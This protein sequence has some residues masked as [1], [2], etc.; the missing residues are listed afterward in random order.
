M[1]HVLVDLCRQG[2]RR[3]VGRTL[4]LERPFRRLDFSQRSND[5]GSIGQCI[6]DRCRKILRRLGGQGFRRAV[7]DIDLRVGWQS[8]GGNE[9]GVSS[10][11]VAARLGQVQTGLRGLPPRLGDH[12]H[13]RQAAFQAGR[14]MVTVP[15]YVL[16][17]A[18]QLRL[19]R[20]AG[21]VSKRSVQV[22]AKDAAGLRTPK[23]TAV[24]EH[25]DSLV[26]GH[27]LTHA[28]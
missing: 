13:G 16:P 9:A 14:R 21:L 2:D 4:G 24:L 8:D 20:E 25:N 1:S 18:E 17:E 7:G 26:E 23:I 3:G 11:L 10:T 5:I 28:R 15:S 6:L 19:W 22:S 27:V 12:D